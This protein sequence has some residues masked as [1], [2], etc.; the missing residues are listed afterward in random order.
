MFIHNLCRLETRLAYGFARIYNIDTVKEF[1]LTVIY[2]IAYFL[3]V[4]YEIKR[5][6]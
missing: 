6:I 4:V 2:Y 3:G 1:T 5:K